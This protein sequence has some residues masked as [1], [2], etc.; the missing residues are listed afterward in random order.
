LRWRDEPAKRNGLLVSVPLHGAA[1][2]ADV[3]VAGEGGE[4]D[5]AVVLRTLDRL[6]VAV[7]VVTAEVV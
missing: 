2:P 6:D 3:A 5:A 7:R 1:V 4:A